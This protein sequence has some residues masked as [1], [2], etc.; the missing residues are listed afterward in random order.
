MDKQFFMF[1]G[2]ALHIPTEQCKWIFCVWCVCV[3]VVVCVCVWERFTDSSL[4]CPIKHDT[5]FLIPS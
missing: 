1:E 3:C 4:W 5:L 2:V